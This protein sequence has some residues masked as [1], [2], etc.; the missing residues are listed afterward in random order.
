MKPTAI[1]L[2]GWDPAADWF[3]PEEIAVQPTAQLLRRLRHRSG[4]YAGTLR[5]SSF[6]IPDVF[7]TARDLGDVAVATMDLPNMPG[8]VQILGVLPAARRN[9]LRAEFA[10]HLTS[11]AAMLNA[12]PASAEL[13][14][15]DGIEA[16]VAQQANSS[17]AFSIQPETLPCDLAIAM[18]HAIECLCG[19]IL[20]WISCACTDQVIETVPCDWHSI[21]I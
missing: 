1:S 21:E 2:Y 6:L 20:A 15:C 3:G 16:A 8:P 13:A 4:W 12:L 7:V 9:R 18:G 14:V 5:C 17:I 11:Y 19:S 10:F